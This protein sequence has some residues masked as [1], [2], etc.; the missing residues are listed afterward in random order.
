MEIKNLFVL[1]LLSST[2][3]SCLQTPNFDLRP[4]GSKK[5]SE[6]KPKDEEAQDQTLIKDV[7]TFDRSKPFRPKLGLVL[8]PGLALS[9]AHIGVLKKL[10]ESEIPIHAIVGMGWGSFTAVEFASEGSVHGLEWR[11]SRSSELKELSSLSFWK[12]TFDEKGVQDLKIVSKT[13]LSSTQTRNSHAKFSCSLYSIK[14]G[15]VVFS[16]HKGFEVCGAVPPLFNPGKT[17]SPFIMGSKEA[18]QAAK[19]LGAEKVIYI[20][21]L[22]PLDLWASKKNYINGSSYWYW[23]LAQAQLLEES[24]AFDKVTRVQISEPYGLLDFSKVLDFVTMGEASGRDL[25]KFLKSEY[26]Y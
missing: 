23:T 2:L 13:L 6:Q 24:K 9:F 4:D 26:Q 12:S 14:L 25:V 15:K 19:D 11:A 3:L 1:L 8:G 7:E 5:E 17:Y 21:V 10:I 18:L 22:T 16:K 20:D